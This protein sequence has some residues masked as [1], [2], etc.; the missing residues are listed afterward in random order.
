MSERTV[1]A[2][3]ERLR[4][5]Q[6]QFIL[7]CLRQWSP[8]RQKMNAALLPFIPA[9][10][11]IHCLQ[12]RLDVEMLPIPRANIPHEEANPHVAH[13]R[14]IRYLISLLA[15]GDPTL[16]ANPHVVVAVRDTLAPRASAIMQLSS[17]KIYK[18]HRRGTPT[19]FSLDS[20]FFPAF[21][22]ATEVEFL[23]RSSSRWQITC[24]AVHLDRITTFLAEH[25]R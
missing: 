13:T 22:L 12:H 4:P 20:S 14:Y 15:D 6:R 25:Y 24:E 10:E 19:F 16:I 7:W 11:A 3:Y 1:G 17:P 8:D 21:S 9:R 23:Q 5:H 2:V 18:L